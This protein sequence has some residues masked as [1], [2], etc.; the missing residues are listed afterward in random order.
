MD[1]IEG[2]TYNSRYRI[3]RINKAWKKLN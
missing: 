3:R 1:H 2:D